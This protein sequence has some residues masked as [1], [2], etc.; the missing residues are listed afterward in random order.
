MY[1]YL[2]KL[3]NKKSVWKVLTWNYTCM[4]YRISGCIIR[5]TNFLFFIPSRVCPH[6]SCP[7][8]DKKKIAQ[9]IVGKAFFRF[10]RNY[11]GVC[12][13]CQCSLLATTTSWFDKEECVSFHFCIILTFLFKPF[14]LVCKQKKSS[15]TT[16]LSCY[17]I[18]QYSQYW[19]ITWYD[20]NKSFYIN[21]A[22]SWGL[23]MLV[24]VGSP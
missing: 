18:N 20:Y 12:S 24:D 23:L 19:L 8:W 4:R 10:A 2:V 22:K 1:T 9:W 15:K 16:Q 21:Q 6:S 3:S 11:P 7:W 13:G 17:Q 5:V 14:I